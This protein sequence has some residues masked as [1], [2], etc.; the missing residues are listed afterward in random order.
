MKRK[1]YKLISGAKLGL[2]A[3]ALVVSGTAHSQIYT[4]AYTGAVQTLTLPA[5]VWGIECWGANGGDAT[6][7]PGGGGKGGYSSGALQVVTNG[8]QLNILVGGKGANCSGTS[9]PGGAGGW[10]GGGGGGTCGKSGGGGGGATDVRVGGT[11]AGNRV[12]VAGGGGGASYYNLLAAGGNGGGPAGQNGDFMSSGNVLTAGG[13]GAGANGASPGI[14][15]PFWASSDGTA[16][17]GGGGGNSPTGFGQQGI[18]GGPGGAGGTIAGGATGGSGGGGGGFAGGAGGSQTTN[19]GVGGG[20]GSGYTGG[21]NNGISAQFNLAGFVPNPDVTGN[22]YVVIT[23]LCSVSLNASSNPICIGQSVTLSTDAIS[24]ITWSGSPSTGNSIVVSPNVT[25]SYSVTGTSTANCVAGSVITIVVNPLPVL[26]AMVTPSTLCVGKTATIIPLGASNYTWNGGPTGSS[27][28]ANPSVNTTYNLAGT[29]QFGCFNTTTIAVNVNT[30][31]LT[32]MPAVSVCKGSALT[33]TASG[34][35]SYTWSS[36]SNFASSVVSP[37]A[38]TTYS[39]SGTD[40][41]D[42]VLSSQVAVT[43]NNKPTVTASASKP[44]ICK[45]EGVTLSASGTANTYTWSNNVI[46]P[47]ASLTLPVDI[48]YSYTVTGED[49]N[50][51]TATAIVTVSVNKCVGISEFSKAGL[52]A[53]VY[54]NPASTL[55]TIELNSSSAKT[56]QVMDLSGRIVLSASSSSEKT[57]LD[58]SGLANGIYYVKLSSDNRSEVFKIVKSK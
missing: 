18:G 43:V 40:V 21:V 57:D 16:T 17:G 4:F 25:T 26:S 58:V 12:I 32:V 23:K 39:V 2:F 41:F 13:G 20:G 22:G 34:A 24:G 38:S 10:N 1:I 19:A 3:L 51:C 49:N 48:V 27:F 36:G 31:S 52:E 54:P 55:L 15:N 47:V 37:Q 53:N 6:A 42:C 30:N 44:T 7:G 33:L 5:G 45:N 50:G 29:S 35:T 28:L 56:I 9:G 14:S 46:G 11:G 8:T